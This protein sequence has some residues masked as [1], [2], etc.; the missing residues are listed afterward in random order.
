MPIV[1][2]DGISVEQRSGTEAELRASLSPEPEAPPPPPQPVKT[3]EPPAELPD[4]EDETTAA[5]DPASEAGKQLARRKQGLKE[6]IDDLT[7]KWRSTEREREQA[8]EEAAELRAKLAALETGGAPAKPKTADSDKPRL[9]AF[10]DRIGSDFTDYEEALEAHADAL[11]DWKFAAERKASTA[12]AATRAYQQALHQSHTRG[13]ETHAD[14]DAI[15]DQFLQ[16]GGAL[17]PAPNSPSGPSPLADLQQT[18]LQHPQGH[19]I[20]YAVAKDAELYQRLLTAPTQIAFFSEMGK[21][22]TRLDGAPAG[23]PSQEAPVSKATPP[24]KPVVG[25]PQA[26]GGPPGDDAS[27]EEHRLYYNQQTRRR[28]A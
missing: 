18:I 8:R 7:F 23:S 3:A 1:E 10:T 20:A 22:I 9:K 6:R 25:Q 19:S 28:R 2:T 5:I 24:V 11:T 26:T 15:I 17:G 4:E 21:L 13:R 12:D 27:D 14:F 16:R